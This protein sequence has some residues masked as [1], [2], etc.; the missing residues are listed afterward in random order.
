MGERLYGQD[1][2]LDGLIPRLVGLE[3]TGGGRVPFEDRD[4]AP[5]VQICGGL[6]SGKSALLNALYEGYHDRVP[7]ARIDL[8]A[9]GFE[10][11]ES[12]D[13]PN[14][15]PVTNVLYLLSYKL[16]LRLRGVRRPPR[17][18]RLSVGLLVVTAWEP[19]GTLPDRL[20]EAERSL[21][22]IVATGDTDRRKRRESLQKWLDA[23]IPLLTNVIALPAPLDEIF[24]TVLTTAR[25]LL[26]AP[27]PDKGALHWW[28]EQLTLA[29][30]DSLQK[31]FSLVHDFR[32]RD[33]SR[34]KAEEHLIAAL[35]ADIDDDYGR[36]HRANRTPLPLILLDNV[37]SPAAAGFFDQL[38]SAYDSLGRIGHPVTRPVVV[39]TSLGDPRP[40]TQLSEVRT[41]VDPGRHRPSSNRVAY[42]PL[43]RLGLPPVRRDEIMG[44]L[45]PLDYPA[46]LPLLLERLSGGR[47]SSARLLADTA[48]ELPA[49]GERLGLADFLALFHDGSPSG[50]ICSALEQLLPEAGLR[51]RLPL[52][53]AA[54]DDSAARRLAAAFPCEENTLGDSPRER[55]HEARRHLDASR[56]NLHPWPAVHG[57]SPFVADRALRA[58]LLM[59]LRLEGPEERWYQMHRRLRSGYTP[60]NGGAEASGQELPYLHHSLALGEVDLVVRVLHERFGRDGC[61]AWL[62]AVNVVCAAPVPPDGAV[63][64]YDTL[65][66]PVDYG[67]CT[68]CADPA[69]IPVHWAVNKLVQALWRQ[70][71]PL[72]VPVDG[73]IQ[74]VRTALLTLYEHV[75]DDDA[76]YRACLEWPKRLD[77]G[78]QAPDLPIGGGIGA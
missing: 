16:G 30:G 59:R 9:P 36:L 31:L 71:D 12:A 21:Q 19:E 32:R 14:S 50:L 60:G 15:S 47:P 39:A 62:S 37:H 69:A 11:G 73:H 23:L 18:P 13:S 17:F 66:R 26:L 56:W 65:V 33:D 48:R 8:A 1:A 6:G 75:E 5:I 58:L 3:R 34:R 74:K 35:L 46:G 38:V 45:S 51:A 67:G 4:R 10:E 77:E 22:E 76:L 28:G 49:T 54:L 57:M 52:L 63:R 40:L 2:V 44:M 27:R 43:L 41:P 25:D 78:V 55:V 29:Q 72:A 64:V 61:T 42:P 24:P 70:S 53:S 7:L 20:R 68:T